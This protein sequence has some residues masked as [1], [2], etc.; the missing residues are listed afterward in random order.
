MAYPSITYTFAS[1]AVISHSEVNQNFSDLVN[2]LSLGTKDAWLN[3]V[4]VV[5]TANA[6]NKATIQGHAAATNITLTVPSRTG[7]LAIGAFPTVQKFT[8]GTAQTYTTPA[9]VKYIRVRVIGGGGGGG[10]SGTASSNAG[11]NGGAS[12]F[13]SSLLT[14]GGGTGGNNSGSSGVPAGGTVTVNS[15]AVDL[16][17]IV[18]GAGV[19]STYAASSGTYVAGGNGGSSPLGGA[20][21]SNKFGAG[22]NAAANSGSGGGGGGTEGTNGNYTGGGGSAGG[23]IDALISSPDATYTYTVGAAGSAGGAG[24]NGFAGG[25]GGAGLIIVEEFYY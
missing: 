4:Q 8:S 19:G 18:G 2:A 14:A 21:G 17:S 3:T 12:S 22:G 6:A 13:G 1:A 11:G 5:S 7:T 16:G 25:T 10:S 15:P 9:N 20:G 23:Y 24:T